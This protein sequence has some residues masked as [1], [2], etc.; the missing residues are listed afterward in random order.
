MRKI[1]NKTTKV[2]RIIQHRNYASRRVPV[3]WHIGTPNFGDD[4]NPK[5]FADIS[6]KKIGFAS[7]RQ[8]RHYVGV[9]SILDR[10][11]SHSIVLGSGLLF[12]LKNPLAEGVTM[13]AVRGDLTAESAKCDGDTLLGDPMVL[14]NLLM[15]VPSVKNHEIGIVPHVSNFN[16]FKQIFGKTHT[17]I[18]P[19]AD[20]KKVL[21][22]IGNCSYI[23]S[24]SLHGLIVADAL[25]IPNIWLAPSI[26]MHGREFKFR[27]YFTTLDRAK[28]PI[29]IEDF[30]NLTTKDLPYSVGAY[31]Y[32]K[33]KYFEVLQAALTNS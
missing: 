27:D 8:A 21:E 13:I 14:L 22:K 16:Q 20:P 25:K 7:D 5:F 12:P 2:F 33:Q 29:S 28:D 6:G 18:D 17:L 26:D 10:A 1:R 4:V 23:A 31:L 11:T 19:S 3:F 9:G 32:D 24:Q 15:D 30:R